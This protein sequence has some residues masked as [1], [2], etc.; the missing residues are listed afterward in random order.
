VSVRRSQRDLNVA[1]QAGTFPTAR[2]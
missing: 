1:V 2:Q